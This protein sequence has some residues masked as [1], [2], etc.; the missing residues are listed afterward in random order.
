MAPNRKE[1]NLEVTP[2]KEKARKSTQVYNAEAL[3]EQCRS[4]TSKSFGLLVKTNNHTRIV[5]FNTQEN[6]NHKLR[7]PTV[8]IWYLKVKFSTIKEVTGL[9]W[10]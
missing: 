3:C 4:K 6:P 7:Y 1:R 8:M 10:P 2:T 9:S 5:F